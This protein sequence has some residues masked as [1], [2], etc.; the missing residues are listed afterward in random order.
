MIHNDPI[1][2]ARYYDH[3]NHVFTHYPIKT[4]LFLNN[5]F[6]FLVIESQNHDSEHD[7]GFLWIKDAPIYGINRNEKINFFVNKYIS[8]D[9]SLL[10]ITLQ[11]A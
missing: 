3:K 6:F 5:F 2:C 1:T 11:N 8:C 4:H 7:H 10:P 9:V